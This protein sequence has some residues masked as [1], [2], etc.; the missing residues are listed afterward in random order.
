MK[1]ILAFGI[2]LFIAYL[3]AQGLFSKKKILSPVN[4]FFISGLIYIVFGVLLGKNVLNVLSPEVLTEF[5][6]LVGLGLG[7][8]GFLFGFQLELR[9]IR[10]FPLK[11]IGFSWLHSLFSFLSVTLVFWLVLGIAFPA[12]SSFLLTGLAISLGI[13][14]SISSSSFIPLVS[15]LIRKGEYYRLARFST[16]IDDFWGLWGIALVTCFWHYPFFKQRVFLNGL[17]LFFGSLIFCFLLSLIFHLL[18]RSTSDSKELLVLL[19][20]MVFFVSGAAVYF[21]LSPIF[22]NMVLGLVFSRLT[23]H[24]EKVYPIF[25][26]TEKPFYIIFLILIGAL[27]DI[28][29][30][31]KIL[32]LTFIFVVFRMISYSFSLPLIEKLLKFPFSLPPVFGLSF[33]SQGGVGIALAIHFKMA[34]PL[35]LTDIL[36][37]IALFGILI[38]EILAP[39]GLRISLV[40][41]E[42]E[43]LPIKVQE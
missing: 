12:H 42:R 18:T 7:W 14:A 38:N 39:W 19:L 43:G 26:S 33:L 23:K 11:Y 4:Y 20:G 1:A 25:I 24:H 13:I 9:Y 16:S 41:L 30:N 6:P 31:L 36:V 29:F 37:S 34:Y 8:I 22:I 17:L 35:P 21:N 32:I 27:W 2:L 3:G 10:Q 40:K 5:R 15:P 28:N